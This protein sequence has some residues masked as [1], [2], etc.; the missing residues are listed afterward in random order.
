M[1]KVCLLAPPH[2]VSMRTPQCQSLAGEA[3]WREH[4]GLGIKGCVGVWRVVS[5]KESWSGDK[6]R[7]WL[8]LWDREGLPDQESPGSMASKSVT[9]LLSVY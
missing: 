9:Q 4:W 8:N 5:P 3:A 7:L 2:P 6:A 1:G